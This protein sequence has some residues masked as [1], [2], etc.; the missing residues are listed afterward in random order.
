[1]LKKIFQQ[2]RKHLEKAH[3]QQQETEEVEV[4]KSTPD[5][6][7]A[8]P[9]RVPEQSAQESFP[10]TSR[11]PE[12]LPLPPPREYISPHQLHHLPPQLL[13]SPP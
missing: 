2:Q 11:E 5:Q 10:S 8:S 4:Y 7:E 1:M 6:P 9:Q 12:T 3:A 13:R